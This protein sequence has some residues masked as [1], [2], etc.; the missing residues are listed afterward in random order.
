MVVPAKAGIQ[1]GD[2]RGN[3]TQSRVARSPSPFALSLSKPVLRA[4]EGGPPPPTR[5]YLHTPPPVYPAARRTPTQTPIHLPRGSSRIPPQRDPLH[6]ITRT[7]LPALPHESFP[8]SDGNPTPCA[9]RHTDTA[10]LPRHQCLRYRL[11]M[12]VTISHR[13]QNVTR[14]HAVGG[15]RLVVGG[16]VRI[17][18]QRRPVKQ[19][20]GL[21]PLCKK[22]LG[23]VAKMRHTSYKSNAKTTSPPATVATPRTP[24][25]L[26]APLPDTVRPEPVEAC[27]EAEAL[28]GGPPPPA[29]PA[30]PHSPTPH[31]DT[32][33][34]PPTPPNPYP[35]PM[36][37]APHT[38][39]TTTKAPAN[40]HARSAQSTPPLNPNRPPGIVSPE[41]EQSR[42]ATQ[43]GQGN[44]TTPPLAPDGT[45]TRPYC[46]PH[47][48]L[49]YRLPM[50]VTISHRNQNVTSPHAV[51]GANLVVG[52]MVCIDGQRRPV[53]QHGGLLPLCKKILGFCS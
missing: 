15:A 21:L 25:Y 52:G 22:I 36:N 35:T 40:T 20:E 18:G 34:F 13:N 19:H 46:P 41:K 26:A 32:S 16:M 39:T 28:E 45:L 17:D 11:P 2:G 27:P 1:R 4:L 5:P 37:T 53:K 38:A 51:G 8:R 6:R 33:P 30:T 31:P 43:V 9:G 10:L 3:P 42:N 14:P 47:R 29:A 44:S 48:C 12:A 24:I 50:A 7:S 49:R 23:F